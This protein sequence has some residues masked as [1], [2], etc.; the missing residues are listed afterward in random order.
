[1]I[2]ATSRQPV[3]GELSGQ[4]QFILTTTYHGD[5]RAVPTSVF[6]SPNR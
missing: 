6:G 4:H 1:M 3:D 2:R 5:G